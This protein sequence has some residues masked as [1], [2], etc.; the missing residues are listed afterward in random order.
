MKGVDERGTFL[1][2]PFANK[3]K[4]TEPVLGA[5]TTGGQYS[6]PLFS[7]FFST[8]RFV[9]QISTDNCAVISRDSILRERS[10]RNVENFSTFYLESAIVEFRLGYSSRL[11]LISQIHNQNNKK[12]L[13]YQKN[14]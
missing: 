6:L 11:F 8:E 1:F 14:P 7:T 5:Q 13:N 2:S 10:R 4:D 3:C 12:T 9:E